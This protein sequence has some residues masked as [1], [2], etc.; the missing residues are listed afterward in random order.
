MTSLTFPRDNS[1][2]AR[3]RRAR[4]RR[5]WSTVSRLARYLSLFLS[6]IRAAVRGLRGLLG[7]P[8]TAVIKNDPYTLEGNTV[9]FPD[10]PVQVGGGFIR[11]VAP[12]VGATNGR[13]RRMFWWRLHRRP[14]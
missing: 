1:G 6:A 7:R 10:V 8:S 9:G 2:T 11:L 5:F 14:I 12:F 13:G 3:L 4:T